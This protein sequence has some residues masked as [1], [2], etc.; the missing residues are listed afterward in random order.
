MSQRHPF[1][2]MIVV[3]GSCLVSSLLGVPAQ[4]APDLAAA[5]APSQPGS[6]VNDPTADTTADA[7][8]QNS[9][10]IAVAGPNLVAAYNDTG[11]SEGANDPHLVGYSTSVDGGETWV[12]RGSVYDGPLPVYGSPALAVNDRSGRVFLATEGGTS[13]TVDNILVFR[14][15]DQ[16]LTFG[17]PVDATGYPVD[18]LGGEVLPN[19]AV[20]NYPGQG[21]GTVYLGWWHA[22]TP[23]G[24]LRLTTSLDSGTSWSPSRPVS[25]DQHADFGRADLVVSPDHCLH[26]VYRSSPFGFEPVNTIRARTSC[27]RGHTFGPERVVATLNQPTSVDQGLNGQFIAATEPQVAVN[28]LTGALYVV[29]HDITSARGADVFLTTST[30]GGASWGAPAR[31]GTDRTGHDQFSASV[32]VTDDGAQLMVGFYDRRNDPFNLDVQRWGQVALIDTA[33]DALLWRS[34]FPLSPSFRPPDCCDASAPPAVFS[35]YEEIAADEDAFYSAWTDNRDGDSF[36]LFQ[37]DI[38]SATVPID[39]TTDLAVTVSGSTTPLPLGSQYSYTATVTNPSPNPAANVIARTG[40]PQGTKFG[41]AAT[42]S[43]GECYRLGRDVSCVLG[44]LG[45]GESRT[46]TFGA[47]ALQSGPLARTVT[48]TTSTPESRRL[49][50]VGSAPANVSSAPTDATTFSTGDIAVRIPAPGIETTYV[51]LEIPATDEISLDID[52]VLRAQHPNV[53]EL[54]IA[55]LAPSGAAVPLSTNNGYSGQQHYGT[56]PNTCSGNPVV[57]DD[58]ATDSIIDVSPRNFVGTFRPEGTLSN[59]AGGQYDGTWQLR[60]IDPTGVFVGTVGCFQ[61]RIRHTT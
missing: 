24:G 33:T 7:T 50:N 20:D 32:A 8:T 10:S 21:R 31:I 41:L 56:G 42:T 4:A 17:A 36:S 9:V 28:P 29:Y 37:P 49:N 39:A 34:D 48:A 16:G 55:L 52:V 58:S 3:A 11:S 35:A 53:Q 6:L 19:L 25:V 59:L 44:T 15:G 12:D 60:I 23:G 5:E 13:D 2:W 38:R 40:L 27:D 43:P 47:Q 30:D 1:D 51:P 57:F 18:G 22:T 61:L 45:P 46:I 26:Y 14:S 54:D